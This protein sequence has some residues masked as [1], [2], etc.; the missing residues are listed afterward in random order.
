M[1]DPT[2]G[3]GFSSLRGELGSGLGSQRLS[4]TGFGSGGVGS[5]GGLGSGAV[6]GSA[7]LIRG[8]GSGGVEMSGDGLGGMSGGGLGFGEELDCTDLSGGMELDNVSYGEL[9]GSVY[10]TNFRIFGRNYNTC[11]IQHNTGRSVRYST[12]GINFIPAGACTV[13]Y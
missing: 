12:I 2:H 3:W 6:L 11:Y 4:G 7:R 10:F 13:S 5:G 1:A 8:S 9:E